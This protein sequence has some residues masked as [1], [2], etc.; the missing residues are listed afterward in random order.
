MAKFSIILPVRNGGHYIRECIRSIEAQTC[1]DF[2]V[3]ILENGSTDGTAE[4]LQTLPAERYTVIPA[5]RPLT[6]EENWERI[7][8]V[9]MA[10]WITLIG[11]DDLL[12]PAFLEQI[13]SLI[14]QHPDASLFHTHFHFIDAA[15]RIIRPC[16]PMPAR[17]SAEGLLEG[18]LTQKV[19]SMGTGYVMRAADYVAAGGIPVRYPN[20]LF[21][22]F[23]LWLRLAEKGGMVIHPE[24]GFAFRVHQS[25]T[26]TSSDSRMISALDCYARYLQSLMQDPA[27]AELI[28]RYGAG[29]LAFYTKGLAHRILRTAP[30]KRPGITVKG[31][32]RHTH[33]L[34]DQLQVGGDYHPERL[35]SLWLAAWIDALPPAG[36]LFRL[37]KKLY[38]KPIL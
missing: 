22:D 32:I 7:L 13:N 28:R 26:G 38:R 18:F 34:A 8:Q 33:A 14:L 27:K 24:P 29:M 30:S 36:W 5:Q 3:T 9:P 16:Q 11:H 4:W 19:D 23:E 20:L 25:T 2:Q 21:A 12:Y 31:L 1:R 37:F 10:E 35:P 17:L 15:G 6:I